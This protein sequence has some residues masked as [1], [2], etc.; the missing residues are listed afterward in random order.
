MQHRTKENLSLAFSI[1]SFILGIIG[2]IA[3]LGI[4]PDTIT[5]GA[6]EVLRILTPL[7]V[8]AAGIIAGWNIH[9]Q[10]M[11]RASKKTEELLAE[12]INLVDVVRLD[13][14]AILHIAYHAYAPLSLE[15][16]SKDIP[17]P[18]Q[19]LRFLRELG[20]MESIKDPELGITL[21]SL[22]T[23]L[24]DY[25]DKCDDMVGRLWAAKDEFDIQLRTNRYIALREQVSE[26][27]RFTQL[28]IFY[29]QMFEESMRL[30]PQMFCNIQDDSFFDIYEFSDGERRYSLKTN[31]KK[32]LEEHPD[33]WM[34]G[35]PDDTEGWYCEEDDSDLYS[36]T[37]EALDGYYQESSTELMARYGITP[38]TTG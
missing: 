14:K 2:I 29:L 32:E 20:L 33:I 28:L 4:P 11:T 34:I 16:I 31:F 1:G 21:W 3:W 5:Q 7:L 19:S 27:S 24:R 6:Y 10:R 36:I 18:E 38:N 8:F 13:S 23:D 26:A 15:E 22:A 25:L 30:E 12:K 17:D 9:V 35:H 37:L